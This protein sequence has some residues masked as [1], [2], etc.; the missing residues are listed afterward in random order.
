MARPSLARMACVVLMATAV[1]ACVDTDTIPREA[2]ELAPESL[3]RRQLQTRVFDTADE[4]HML[5]ASAGLLQDLGFTIAESETDLGVIVASKRRDARE[6]NQMVAASLYKLTYVF[7]TFGLYWGAD[8]AIDNWQEIQV[9]L[10]T[11][12]SGE[13][14]GRMAV[15]ITFQR[16]VSGTPKTRYRGG[17]PS[18]TRRS[19]RRSSTHCRSRYF[20]KPTGSRTHRA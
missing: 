9:S 2:L 4:A 10:V 7:L 11:M 15:R 16:V 3:A 17:R 12:P 8:M 14:G 18:R 6:V 5:A 20:S 13:R 1:A 19:T